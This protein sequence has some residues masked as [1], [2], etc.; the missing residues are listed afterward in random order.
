MADTRRWAAP[1]AAGSLLAA[2]LVLTAAADLARCGIGLT[3]TGNTTRTVLLVASG[4][5]AAGASVLTAGGALQRRRWA[6][7][8][9]GLVG[10]A[11]APQAAAS[12]FRSP[13]DVPDVAT[14]V[15][16]LLLMATVLVGSQG[17]VIDSTPTADLPFPLERSSDGRR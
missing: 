12:G 8:S 1:A 17:A 2:L 15:L 13:Y 9:A 3:I 14:A 11:S 5:L 6:L 16:G 7:W 10:L 4:V